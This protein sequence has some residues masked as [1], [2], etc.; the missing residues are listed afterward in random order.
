MSESIPLLILGLGNVLCSD[1]GL[2]AA[3]VTELGRRYACP[4]GVEI[5]DGG[6]L[7]LTLLPLLT[8]AEN[9]ILV[10]AVRAPGPAGS[11]VRLDGADVAPAAMERLSPHQIG[12]ADLLYGARWL[13]RYPGTLVLLGL[14]PE[15]IELGLSRSPA[16]TAA[17][18]RLVEEVAIEARR[19]GYA[20]IPRADDEARADAG[21][22]DVARVLG[23]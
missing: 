3:A 11:L 7:G 19:L 16:V 23:L 18:P 21:R 14:V 22:P 13:G 6:T 4:E 15:T 9:A 17:L 8:S 12:V 2:G 1:D 10:D 5:A 20:L